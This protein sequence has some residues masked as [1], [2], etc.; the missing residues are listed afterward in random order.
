ML[1]VSVF[2]PV[3]HGSTVVLPEPLSGSTTHCVLFLVVLMCFQCQLTA[4]C[5]SNNTLFV[6]LYETEH[7]FGLYSR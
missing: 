4:V 6:L 7:M 3:M 1:L 5:H 2:I